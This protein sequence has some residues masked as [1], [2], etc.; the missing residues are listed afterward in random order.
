[1]GEG[2]RGG[3]VTQFVRG[4]GLDEFLMERGDVARQGREQR[5]RRRADEDDGSFAARIKRAKDIGR[6]G[7]RA[8]KERHAALDPAHREGSVEDDHDSPGGL[9]G[10]RGAGRFEERPC[11]KQREGEH[12][13]RAERQENEGAESVKGLLAS[14]GFD[15]ELERR[16]R[17]AARAGAG[18]VVNEHR[19]AGG[20]QAEEQPRVCEAEPGHGM[21]NDE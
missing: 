4:C 17:D 19:Q 15:E 20:E 16:K 12:G 6:L 18:Q 9:G 1:L 7:L 13:H 21:T 5:T 8:G 11:E 10:G 2:K 3:R 14:T